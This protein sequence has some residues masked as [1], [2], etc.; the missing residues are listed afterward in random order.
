MKTIKLS[1]RSP[2]LVANATSAKFTAPDSGTEFLIENIDIENVGVFPL[3]KYIEELVTLRERISG[4]PGVYD[5]QASLSDI[6]YFSTNKAAE[7]SGTTSEYLLF[8]LQ[9]SIMEIG[10]INDDVALHITKSIVDSVSSTDFFDRVSSG[11]F[12]TLIGLNEEFSI[13]LSIAFSDSVNRSESFGSVR[14]AGGAPVDSSSTSETISKAFQMTP[15]VES[16]NHSE[17]G[18]IGIQNYFLAD[19]VDQRYNTAVTNF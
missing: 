6:M 5:E 17:S 11:G 16:A 9:R 18:Y 14:T 7:D 12:E 8:N 10:R 3:F 4:L 13:G 2:T 15:I 19:F 1:G